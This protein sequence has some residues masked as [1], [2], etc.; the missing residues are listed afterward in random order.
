MTMLMVIRMAMQGQVKIIKG[1]MTVASSRLFSL[2]TLVMVTSMCFQWKEYTRDNYSPMIARSGSTD[3]GLCPSPQQLR[4][5]LIQ[6]DFILQRVPP[7]KLT[8]Y[9]DT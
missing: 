3:Y 6:N 8:G 1:M 9:S 2:V 4:L 7:K 5:P